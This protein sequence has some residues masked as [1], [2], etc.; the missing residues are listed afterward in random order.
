VRRTALTLILAALSP[1]LFSYKL[2]PRGTRVDVIVAK[3]NSAWYENIVTKIAASGVKGF[4]EP[5]HEEI[6]NRMFDCP[7]DVQCQDPDTDYAGPYV[8]AGV[9]W[10]DDPPF[11]LNP[12]QAQNTVCKTDQTIRFTT[13]P[14]CWAAL[15]RDAEKRA[16]SGQTLN[17]ASHSSLLA[18]SHYG[19]LQFLHAMASR[20]GE[21]ASETRTYVMMWAEFT[22]RIVHGELPIDTSLAKVQIAGFDKFFGGSGWLVQDLF[23]TG[24]PQLRRRIRDVAFGSLLHAVEDSFAR[25]HV[26]RSEVGEGFCPGLPDHPALGH[27]REFHSYV[28]Q[29]SSKHGEYDKREA[30][31]R[32][33]GSHPGLVDVGK[34]LLQYQESDADWAQVRPYVDCVFMVTDSNARASAGREFEKQN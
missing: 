34:A 20:D 13:Q 9:R 6:T 10:N 12:G 32:Q 18:R 33:S 31:V 14:R 16:V 11:I 22:W 5:V 2:S 19:D 24:N 3:R 26:D 28:H 7:D 29:D 21:L 8:L 4:T 23:A 15:Y 17:A 27:I 1:Q 30:F 25:G